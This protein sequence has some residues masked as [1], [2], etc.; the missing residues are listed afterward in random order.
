LYLDLRLEKSQLMIQKK[1]YEEW[2][3]V[4]DWDIKAWTTCHDP[5]AVCGPDFSGAEI[6]EAIRESLHR[7]GEDDPSG[8]RL[9][10]GFKCK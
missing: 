9:K 1:H 3:Q 7:T 5:V 2:Q 8:A 10:H 6:K 4:L